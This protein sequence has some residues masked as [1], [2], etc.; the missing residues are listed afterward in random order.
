MH[1]C[2]WTYQQPESQRD[3]KM[4]SVLL[5]FVLTFTSL[6]GWKVL[7]TKAG[8]YVPDYP[9]YLSRFLTN[10]LMIQL[11]NKFDGHFATPLEYVISLIRSSLGCVR[12]LNHIYMTL[13]TLYHLKKYHSC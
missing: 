7:N 4:L 11:P 12:L 1:V 3:I 2:V 10:L 13:K 5:P 6:T 8:M 9:T